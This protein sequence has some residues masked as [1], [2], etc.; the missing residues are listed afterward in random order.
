MAGLCLADPLVD[1]F[2]LL[3]CIC[4]SMGNGCSGRYETFMTNRQ[5]CWNDAFK[6]ARWQHCAVELWARF[7]MHSTTCE[8]VFTKCMRLHY[9]YSLLSIGGLW[10]QTVGDDCSE[11]H[12]SI[13]FSFGVHLLL[14]PSPTTW[15]RR[16][17]RNS[18]ELGPDPQNY[19]FSRAN[20]SAAVAA[21]LSICLGLTDISVLY[22]CDYFGG[23]PIFVPSH[24]RR[25]TDRGLRWTTDC[26]PNFLR[27]PKTGAQKWVQGAFFF[28]VWR[29][30]ARYPC[31]RRGL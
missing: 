2:C 3:R 21:R 17:P 5:W 11:F 18:G 15:R 10:R 27:S 13:F 31:M 28:E 22:P 25:G 4:N 1:R 12:P 24:I 19:N 6:F 20:K 30:I 16:G 9:L 14:P 23:G 26:S 8:E 29:S 7:A